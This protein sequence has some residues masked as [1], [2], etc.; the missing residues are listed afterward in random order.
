MLEVICHRKHTFCKKRHYRPCFSEE[1]LT[2]NFPIATNNSCNLVCNLPFISPLQ[3]YE[4]QGSETC[5]FVF[6]TLL[7]F[8]SKTKASAINLVTAT[9]VFPPVPLSY[10]IL[11][12]DLSL[13]ES[14][15]SSQINPT[16]WIIYSVLF[17]IIP[18]SK[19]SSIRRCK[20]SSRYIIYAC[21]HGKLNICLHA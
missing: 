10:T 6:F 7:V 12:E 9:T 5:V 14:L 19:R 2:A 8:T 1:F 3:Q 18:P 15:P 11:L 4:K 16:R 21:V 20:N 13:G 17:S